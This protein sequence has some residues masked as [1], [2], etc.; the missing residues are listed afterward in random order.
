MYF[1]LFQYVYMKLESNGYRIHLQVYN[2]FSFYINCYALSIKRI[3]CIAYV[4]KRKNC[5]Q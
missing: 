1:P 3:R 4:Y 5:M 2:L